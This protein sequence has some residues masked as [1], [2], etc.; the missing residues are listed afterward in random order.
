MASPEAPAG[1]TR[2]RSRAFGLAVEHERGLVGLPGGAGA[3]RGT[4]TAIEVAA[5]GATQEPIGEEVR[6]VCDPDGEIA[7]AVHRDEGQAYLLSLPGIGAYRV[8]ADGLLVT[9]FPA[10]GAADW[11]WQRAIVNQVLPLAAT[12][13]G[14]EVLHAG[15][16]GLDGRVVAM[17]GHPGAGKSS[18][19]LNLVLRGATFFT[20]DALAIE[21]V[22][23][24]LVAHPGAGVANFPRSERE[25]MA[26]GE[27]ERLGSVVGGA[28]AYKSLLAVEREE[29][30]LP[31]GGLYFL[32]RGAS[33]ARTRFEPVADAGASL[34]LGSTYVLSVRSRRRL[35]NQL[36][37]CAAIAAQTPIF[38]VHIPD[39]VGARESAAALLEHATVVLAGASP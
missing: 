29:G 28:G 10:A 19:T 23:D 39:A 4:A 13:R 12:L 9:C 27:P 37:L 2:L 16:V 38:D 3:G 1:A 35:A 21:R 18:T 11:L 14:L 26:A 8:A 20:D 15:A 30:P 7:L 36:D 17:V 24:G 31:L 5:P 25:L 34:L 22:D 32:R 6:M 33:G